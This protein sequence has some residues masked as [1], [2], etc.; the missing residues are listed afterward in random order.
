MVQYDLMWAPKGEKLLGVRNV[1]DGGEEEGCLIRGR[2]VMAKPGKFIK[3][4][5]TEDMETSV[6]C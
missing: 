5:L 4:E 3:K 6:V 2:C 1:L